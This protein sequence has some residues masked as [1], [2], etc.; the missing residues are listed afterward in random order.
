MI[1]LQKLSQTVILF[2]YRW[3]FFSPFL[4]FHPVGGSRQEQMK[5]ANKLL[6]HLPTSEQDSS[7]D[8]LENKHENYLKEVII[9]LRAKLKLCKQGNEFSK[10]PAELRSTRAE[11]KLLDPSSGPQMKADIELLK[12]EVKDTVTHVEGNV[13]KLKDEGT[14]AAS[15]VKAQ[16]SKGIEKR[17]HQQ[18]RPYTKSGQ[19]ENLRLTSK[20]HKV[21]LL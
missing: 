3:C 17:E 10:Q 20:T 11:K 1:A 14:I 7:S 6:D 16:Q 8:E 4:F 19:Q 2:S 12:A 15:E 5:I 21:C 9:Q 18:V 13:T